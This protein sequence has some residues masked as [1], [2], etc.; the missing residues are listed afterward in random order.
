MKASVWGLPL[1]GKHLGEGVCLCVWGG[2]LKHWRRGD[3]EEKPPWSFSQ[4]PWFPMTPP[5]WW[6]KLASQ[7]SH[8]DPRR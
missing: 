6:G 2:R 7:S 1:W 4:G 5:W 3:P 8:G